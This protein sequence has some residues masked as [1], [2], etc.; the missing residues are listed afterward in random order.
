MRLS[1]GKLA[2]CGSAPLWVNGHMS[3]QSL[4]EDEEIALLGLLREVIQA[5]AEYS[6]GEREAVKKIKATVGPDRFKRAMAAAQNR[7]DNRGALKEFV[8]GITREEAR[9][10]IYEALQD[11]AASDGIDVREEKPLHW[12]ASWWHLEDAD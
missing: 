1:A 6:D 7:F 2:L 3:L 5:D 9:R 8:K 10:A 11:V 4:T 12:L